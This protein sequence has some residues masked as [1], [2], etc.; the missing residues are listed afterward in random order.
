VGHRI[1]QEDE[2]SVVTIVRAPDIAQPLKLKRFEASRVRPF[3]ADDAL[4]PSHELPELWVRNGALY[5]SRVAVL[6]EGRLVEAEPLGYPMP[7]ERSIDINT[8][9]DLAFCEFLL[10]RSLELEARNA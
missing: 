6:H 9:L 8:P 7:E 5:A 2:R 1:V 4:T 3:I 10:N